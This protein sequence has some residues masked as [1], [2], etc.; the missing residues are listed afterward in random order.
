MRLAT[1]L[2]HH[3]C[4]DKNGDVYTT[5]I[6]NLD[7][8][9]IARSSKTYG[10]EAYY[11]VTPVEAQQELGRAIA[12]FW[13][14]KKSRERVPSRAQALALARVVDRIEDAI[15]AETES[16]G[17]RPLVLT[18]SAKAGEDIVAWSEARGRIA[19]AKGVL[20]LFGTGY[21][22]A[23]E[24]LAHG[25]LM[26]APVLGTDDY[27]H[28]SVRSAAAIILDRLRSPDHG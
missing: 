19:G 4:V 6:T 13:E 23:P 14:K 2:V 12:T 16:L 1:A 3:P 24:A 18:T 21:G 15:A 5:S 28:L 10:A 26:L 22:L 20:L 17:E 8:H 11:L 27:N 25:D 9:D 7:V